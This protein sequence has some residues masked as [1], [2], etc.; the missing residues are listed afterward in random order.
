MPIQR[1]FV[2]V[3]L[4]KCKVL[5]APQTKNYLCT[6]Y[7]LFTLHV[8][9]CQWDK[10]PENL[11][12]FAESLHHCI[13]RGA[14]LIWKSLMQCTSASFHNCAHPLVREVNILQISVVQLSALFYISR[15]ESL[16]YNNNEPILNK[17]VWVCAP[18]WPSGVCKSKIVKYIANL[19][20]VL[21]LYMCLCRAC[22]CL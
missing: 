9:H 20:K 18:Y 6:N 19:Q 16:T 14:F 22:V 3:P 1:Q 21:A 13:E 4:A 15:T 2:V 5:R 10:Q 17:G 8:A 7:C 11:C 12:T